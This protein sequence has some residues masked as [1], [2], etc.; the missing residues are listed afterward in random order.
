MEPSRQTRRLSSQAI[1]KHNGLPPAQPS[2][3]SLLTL[4]AEILDQIIKMVAEHLPGERNEI[5]FQ[6]FLEDTPRDHNMYHY[7]RDCHYHR[8]SWFH[9]ETPVLNSLQSLSSV[10]RKLYELCRPLRWNRKLIYIQSK[11]IHRC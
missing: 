9:D 3:A 8:M 7:Y 11:V 6:R 4:P 5:R 1:R 10:S 2:G